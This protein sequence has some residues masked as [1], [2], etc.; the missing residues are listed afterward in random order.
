M[1]TN[2]I[3]YRSSDNKV[4]SSERF[5]SKVELRELF[6]SDQWVVMEI[7]YVRKNFKSHKPKEWG[8]KSR[9]SKKEKFLKTGYPKSSQK[10][11]IINI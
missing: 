4:H 6:P 8:G 7:T 10:S 9:T 11:R 1:K 3:L 2:G 5:L